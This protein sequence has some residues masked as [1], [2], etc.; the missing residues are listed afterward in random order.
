MPAFGSGGVAYL[1]VWGAS[2][3]ATTYS[4]ALVYYNVLGAGNPSPVAEAASHEMGHNLGLSH[5]GT[6]TIGY[7]EGLGVGSVSWAPIMG[8]GYYQNVTEWSI[9]E[10]PG[11]N[12]KQDDISI[13]T[14]K[15]TGRADDHSNVAT[16]ATALLVDAAG[17]ITVTNPET[18]PVNA[19]PD[20]KGVIGMRSDVD[21]FTF[22]AGA[23]PLQIN[24]NS[25]ADAFKRLANKGANLDI[26]ATLYD[27]NGV[28]VVQVDPINDT[29]AIITTTVTAAN[30]GKFYLA[31][32]GVGN[33]TTP[34]SDYASLGQY[35]ISGAVTPTTVVPDTTAPTPDPMAWLVTPNAGGSVN[36]ISMQATVATDNSGSAVQYMFV[37][38]SGSTGCVNSSWQASNVYT[39]TGLAAATTYNYQVKAKDAAGNETGLSPMVAATTA[40]TPTDTTPPAPNPG[41]AV[42]PSAG[43][44]TNSISMTS[45]VATDSSG[46]VQYMFVCA[47]GG[48]VGCVSSNWQASTS[49]TATGLAAATT[50][51][52]QV[53]AKD[54]VGNETVLSAVA[55]AKTA[56]VVPVLL[57]PTLTATGISTS[58]VSLK[59]NAVSSATGYQLWYCFISGTSCVYG[60]KP[61]G[62]YVGTSVT[63]S[64]T[65]GSHYRF[66]VKAINAAGASGFSNEVQY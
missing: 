54:A 51:N 57:A 19:L 11:A 60:A 55:S 8:V 38:A 63:V 14:T 48:G 26:S 2:N 23:G 53:K 39:A 42:L 7:Y 49:Y 43:V 12:N 29:N 17:V 3:Y 4:P 6:A 1:N 36:S 58:K 24:V 56:S 33:A 41:W 34:Y 59:W 13:I 10:Y 45:T 65:A 35:Y 64:F 66:K 16:G 62:T 32:D 28:Q 27:K 52:F 37:C 25:A 44:S 5:D 21:Y 61:L 9:G 40:A 47:P 31:I 22:N 30:A 18:D 20:N 15:L 46:P 50:Y